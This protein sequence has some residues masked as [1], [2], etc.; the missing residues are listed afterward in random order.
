VVFE[1]VRNSMRQTRHRVE[2]VREKALEHPV[3]EWARHSMVGRTI[4]NYFDDDVDGLAA[5]LAYN[6]LFSLIPVLAAISIIV[7]VVVD[8]FSLRDEIS[9]MVT[10]DVPASVYDNVADT[11]DMTVEHQ[12]SIGSLTLLTL[13]YG[14]SRLY[15]ALDR[16]FAVVYRSE[17]RRYFRRK[18]FAIFV[19]PLL[20]IT[21]VAGTIVAATATGF[22]TT[23]LGNFFDINTSVQD[24]V[25]VYSIAFV[26]GFVVTL[27]PYAV[28]P[29]DGA[30]W[31]GSVPGAAAAG[32]LFVF[33]SQLY[34]IYIRLTGGYNTYGAAFG[35][36]LLFM[37]WLYLAAQIIVIGAEICA[38]TSGV[39]ARN[40]HETSIS[41][42]ASI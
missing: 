18:L 5:M 40:L 35:L 30:G 9:S 41:E 37:F 1:S 33:L 13:L 11:V 2:V 19:T 27:I 32:V 23:S 34:P 10:D 38:V 20:A 12:G 25:A 42:S 16:A 36:V 7:G 17:R 22:L 15:S 14:G 28:I 21:L 6:T 26:M 31:R 39:R 29:A 24:F 4:Q 8:N 3:T